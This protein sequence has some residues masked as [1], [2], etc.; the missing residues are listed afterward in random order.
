MRHVDIP[1]RMGL[2]GLFLMSRWK[3]TFSRRDCIN[4]FPDNSE[5]LAIKSR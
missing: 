4:E 3:A 2:A 5:I 1:Y